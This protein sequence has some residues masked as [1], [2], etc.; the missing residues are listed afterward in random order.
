MKNVANVVNAESGLIKLRKSIFD[1]LHGANLDV[2]VLAPV[3]VH[4]ANVTS[5]F[6]HFGT[7][8]EYLDLFTNDK[9]LMEML[10]VNLVSHCAGTP[11]KYVA[12]K[13]LLSNT[14]DQ[15]VPDT[16]LGL[17]GDIQAHQHI[18]VLPCV[19]YSVVHPGVSVGERSI[20]EYCTLRE[21]VAIGRNSIVSHCSLT[22]N[23]SIPAGTFMHTVPVYADKLGYSYTV[24]YCTIVF[25]IDDNLKAMSPID[26][27]SQLYYMGKKLCEMFSNCEFLFRGVDRE[28]VSL[29]ETKLFEVHETAEE[30]SAAT[31]L[32][33]KQLSESGS[34]E[35]ENRRRLS[36]RD[37]LQAKNVDEVLRYRAMLQMCINKVQSDQSFLPRLEQFASK[38]AS[39]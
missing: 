8:H 22:K 17:M 31:C 38:R 9:L 13:G 34:V 1:H 4:L 30:S 14:S 2:V 20:V 33:L 25:G 21:G 35:L 7:S 10:S 39:H 11:F 26:F 24:G 19:M 23:S 5:Q 29:W 6:Y 27:A 37:L 15:A 32:F 18:A 12:D 28:S 16:V 3:S 36:M